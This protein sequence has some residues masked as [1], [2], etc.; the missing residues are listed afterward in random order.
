MSTTIEELADRE[1]IGRARA[2]NR[3]VD[4]AVARRV[5]ARAEKIRERLYREHGLLNVVVELLRETRDE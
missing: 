2:E 5:H 1:E 4:A 3:P